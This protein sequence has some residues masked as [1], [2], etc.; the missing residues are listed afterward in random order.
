[1]VGTPS[2]VD[3]IYSYPVN[4]AKKLRRLTVSLA[5]KKST[6]VEYQ[7][8]QLAGVANAAQLHSGGSLDVFQTAPGQDAA[9]KTKTG[10]F[11]DPQ[12]RLRHGTY[13]AGETNFAEN[14][15]LGMNRPVQ[16]TA[17]QGGNGC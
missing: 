6:S 1:M 4:W 10:R 5:R 12:F 8:Q 2:K 3:L 14:H 16:M 13:F 17:G 9:R 7:F 11:L 15:R